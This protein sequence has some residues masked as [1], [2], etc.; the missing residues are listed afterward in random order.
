MKCLVCGKKAQLFSTIQQ[1]AS[2]SMGQI[3]KINNPV[4]IAFCSILCK[5]ED[6]IN[7]NMDFVNGKISF[8]EDSSL[9]SLKNLKILSICAIYILNNLK[10]KNYE[11][12]Y[13]MYE[14]KKSKMMEWV[15][16][17]NEIKLIDEDGKD[18]SA[19]L[20]YILMNEL[21]AIGSFVNL[22]ID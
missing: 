11:K 1:Y 17:I 16:E 12:A 20:Y 8:W 13:T 18:R 6:F 10:S 4:E 5:R 2:F 7:G 22:S 14:S 15:E 19:E 9:S 21:V 3:T